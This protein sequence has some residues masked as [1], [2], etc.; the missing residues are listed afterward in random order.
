MW[1]EKCFI[2]KYIR[3]CVRVCVY[4]IHTHAHSV[5]TVTGYF[6]NWSKVSYKTY[7]PGML[8]LIFNPT[9]NIPCLKIQDSQY[10]EE[11]YSKINKAYPNLSRRHYYI[12]F[13]KISVDDH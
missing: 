3:V 13:L 2:Y 5:L 4:T 10:I 7:F 11:V 9:V 6:S 1:S 8:F 12:P